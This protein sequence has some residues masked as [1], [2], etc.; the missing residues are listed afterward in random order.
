MVMNGDPSRTGV[1]FTWPTLVGVFGQP[2][3][4]PISSDRT[5]HLEAC[6]GM[7]PALVSMP[8]Y[9][10]SILAETSLRGHLSGDIGLYVVP[11][12]ARH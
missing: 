4:E 9:C 3:M 10:T 7:N 8:T 12:H 2:A 11:A 5:I 6:G 1:S